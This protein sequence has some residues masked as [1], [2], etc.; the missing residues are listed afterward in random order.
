[1]RG[2]GPR[3]RPA[4]QL[5]LIAG[6]AFTALV[7]SETG[8]MALVLFFWSLPG[9]IDRIVPGGVRR[10]LRTIQ[11]KPAIGL[12]PLAVPLELVHVVPTLGQAGGEAAVVGALAGLFLPIALGIPPDR[13]SPAP[14]KPGS[15]ER[16]MSAPVPGLVAGFVQVPKPR[17]T[18]LGPAI[19]TLG[20]AAAAIVGAFLPWAWFDLPGIGHV[21]ADGFYGNDPTTSDGA[22]ALGVAVAI[23]IV[24]T[25]RLGARGAAGWRR[26]IAISGGFALIT[27][28][29]W[30]LGTPDH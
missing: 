14:S 11:R 7:R 4:V 10:V 20:G 8:W 2:G 23:A 21:T 18:S 16:P 9:W 27:V 19:V 25:A 3:R 1:M 12:L 17:L 28:A 13:A 5:G 30:H 22:L 29:A 26:G 6:L 15:R 24:A